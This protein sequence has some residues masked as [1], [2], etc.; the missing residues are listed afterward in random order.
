M[1]WRAWG[2]QEA[3]DADDLQFADLVAAVAVRCGAV[4]HR[5]VLPGQGFELLGEVLLVALHGEQVVRVAFLHQVVGVG[6]FGVQG[7]HCDHGVLQFLVVDLLQQ[8]LELGISLVL[9]PISRAATVSAS[10][11]RTADRK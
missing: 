9:A 3:A 2:E 6:A 10:S 1:T 8:G 7:V 11:W 5:D 4:Q